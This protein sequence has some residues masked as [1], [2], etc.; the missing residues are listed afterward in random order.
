MVK[1]LPFVI[2]KR[3]SRFMKCQTLTKRTTDH[4]N[5]KYIHKHFDTRNLNI[6]CSYSRSAGYIRK[7]GNSM[8]SDTNRSAVFLLGYGKQIL[9]LAKLGKYAYIMEV[10]RGR[11]VPRM[12]KTKKLLNIVHFLQLQVLS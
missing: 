12:P 9:F 7:K 10:L 5:A 6:Q 8:Y 4:L 11:T 2:H 1:A 3:S